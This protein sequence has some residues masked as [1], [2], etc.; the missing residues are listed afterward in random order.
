MEKCTEQSTA[1]MKPATLQSTSEK[2]KISRARNK[3]L[4]ALVRATATKPKTAKSKNI[5]AAITT[6]ASKIQPVRT[7]IP[8]I[9]KEELEWA[10]TL[11]SKLWG[12]ITRVHNKKLAS[13]IRARPTKIKTASGNAKEDTKVRDFCKLMVE[14]RHKLGK[15]GPDED[16]KWA[17]ML[18]SELRD[19]YFLLPPSKRFTLADSILTREYDRMNN[20][21]IR[22]RTQPEKPIQPKKRVKTSPDTINAATNQ[23][24]APQPAGTCK[25]QVKTCSSQTSPDMIN[26]ATNQEPAPQPL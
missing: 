22:K 14:V 8:I 21:T 12:V 10:D 16:Q 3:K 26:A 7:K 20:P 6:A 2:K 4:T 9:S 19:V 13:V 24:S 17:N 23:E 25:K 11:H 1:S 15:C 18:Y 5:T